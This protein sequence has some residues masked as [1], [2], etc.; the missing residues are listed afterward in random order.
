MLKQAVNAL[1]G[2]CD[3]ARAQDGSGFNRFDG[4]FIRSLPENWSPRQEMAVYNL[5][6]KY[7]SQLSRFGINYDAIEKP[8]LPPAP[9]PIDMDAIRAKLATS[10][11]VAKPNIQPASPRQ[12]SIESGNIIVEFPWNQTDVDRVKKLIPGARFKDDNGRK[13]WHAPLNIGTAEGAAELSKVINFAPGAYEQIA[14]IIAKAHANATLSRAEDGVRLDFTGFGKEPRPFQHGG[15]DYW[16]KND[17]VLIADDMGLGK[18]IQALG[19][20]FLLG[21]KR[22]LIN[23]PATV[24]V[25]WG[26]EAAACLPGAQKMFFSPR[27]NSYEHYDQQG[28]H[29]AT[30]YPYAHA[31]VMCPITL[32][33]VCDSKTPADLVA[34]A[35]I[36]V[37]NYD[38]NSAGWADDKKKNVNLTP[39]AEA[40]SEGVEVYVCDESHYLKNDKAQR[41]RASYQISRNVPHRALLTGTP[42]LN[43][44]VELPSQLEILDRLSEFGGKWKFLQRYTN[45]HQKNAGRKMVWDFS[46]A[47]NLEELNAKLRATCYI[48]RT[49]DQ[50]LTEL[51]PKTYETLSLEL[52][53]RAEYTKAEKDLVKYIREIAY[54]AEKTKSIDVDEDAGTP[55]EIEARAQL[56]AEIAAAK[57]ARAK[58]LVGIGVLRKL[59]AQ[60]KIKEVVSFVNDFMEGDQK[61]VIFAHHIEVQQ[62]LLGALAQWGATSVMGSD[63]ATVRA[64]HVARFQSD[65]GCR[66]I[67]CSLEAAAEGITLTAASTVLFVEQPWTPGKKQQAEDRCHRIGQNDNV[68]VYDTIAP[69]SFDEDLAALLRDKSQIVSALADGNQQATISQ[70]REILNRIQARH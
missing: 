7:K 70:L 12:I 59:C 17:R 30:E 24:K 6:R 20:I 32:V 63:S 11:V 38:L 57:A 43:R 68:T 42:I 3:G 31:R 39:L 23:C 14:G 53:N 33:L 66:V 41:T 28:N 8:V 27:K 64:E 56:A 16:L 58:V 1:L 49:K 35:N 10:P 65:P 13:M 44:P 69:M 29:V 67:V 19:G 25:N 5:L 61:L 4:G 45:A 55:E 62:E 34:K 48:R 60:G 40:A 47:S 18:T 52:A 36:L 46:G 9:P 21:A 22:A 26:K 15:V 37:V 54:L 2:V 50:V 51:P